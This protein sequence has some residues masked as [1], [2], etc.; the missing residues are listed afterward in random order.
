[1][2]YQSLIVDDS[3]SLPLLEPYN[4]IKGQWLL[5][6]RSLTKGEWIECVIDHKPSIEDVKS[7]VLAWHNKQ[8]DMA[9]LSGHKW[10][11]MAIWLSPENQQNYKASFDL[12]L[13]FGGQ[14]GTLPLTY[15]FG[16]ETEPIYHQFETLEELKDFYLSTVLYVKS[17]LATGWERKDSI[18]WSVY[19]KAL[20]EYE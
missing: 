15:K 4:P 10:R 11:D 18:D 16:T 13:Q 12:A 6:W 8:I 17:V 1:M 9:I 5:R 3:Q 7:Y 19:D 2:Q 14:G 20:Q